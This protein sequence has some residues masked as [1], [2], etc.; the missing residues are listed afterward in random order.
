MPF[1]GVL[2]DSDRVDHTVGGARSV[3]VREPTAPPPSNGNGGPAPAVNRAPVFTGGITQERSIAEG[4]APG[5]NVGGP[6]A[7]NDPDND[8][9]T[10]RLLGTDM[11]S[12]A[13][14]NTGQITVGAGTVLDYETKDTYS[15][16]VRATDPSNAT[17]SAT[18][19][20][21]V[22]NVDETGMIILSSTQPEVGV[23][24]TAVLSDPDGGVSGA[25]WSWAK[26]SDQSMW[27][28]HQ[29]GHVS[30]LYTGCR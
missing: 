11:G 4:E 30:H 17:A 24:L 6:I 9:I 28:R 8:S 18:V 5:T 1:S 2:R 19:T 29:C 26:S 23:G 25:T 15:V 21:S 27:D 7:A 12:F 20:I 3:T 14:S 16:V 13:V 10:Y 22:T